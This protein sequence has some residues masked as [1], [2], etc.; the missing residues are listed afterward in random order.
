MHAAR[1]VLEVDLVHD[2]DARRH[3]LERV[4][5]LHAP[6][7]ELVAL[8][9]ALELELHVEVERVLACRSGRPCTEWSTTR[10]TGTSGSITF[11]FLPMSLATLRIAAR[12]PSSG[13]AGEVLQHDA[14]DDERNLVG[15]RARSA[16]SRRARCTCCL[17]HL[18]AVAVAQHRLEHDA[19]RDRKP[20]DLADARGL[21][22]RQRIDSVPGSARSQAEAFVR[23][24]EQVVS[25][26]GALFRC[27]SDCGGVSA[28]GARLRRRAS[29]FHHRVA[30]IER[31]PVRQHHVAGPLASLARA[32]VACRRCTVVISVCTRAAADRRSLS[33]LGAVRGV[34]GERHRRRRSA[35]VCRR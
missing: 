8:G 1:Q 15:A 3:D 31:L 29:M 9:V 21:E 18:L 14:R 27:R 20:R 10:S 5:R 7:H 2:A 30:H 24:I 26:S 28:G 4:E 11:G 33:T 23:R 25:S 16:P 34:A 17:G 6:F 19:D 12:S 13:H 32:D 22:R 35:C